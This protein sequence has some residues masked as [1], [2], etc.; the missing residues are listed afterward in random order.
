MPRSMAGVA[1]SLASRHRP[2]GVATGTSSASPVS[3]AIVRARP[4]ARGGPAFTSAEHGVWWMVLGLGVGRSALA[5]LSTG[6][7]ARAPPRG[8]RPCSTT[9]P[10]AQALDLGQQAGQGGGL[11]H[12]LAVPRVDLQRLDAEPLAGRLAY[13]SGPPGPVAGRAMQA[14]LTVDGNRYGEFGHSS[15]ARPGSVASGPLLLVRCVRVG[16]IRVGGILR[17]AITR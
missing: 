17:V 7:W 4:S 1:A 16:G 9:W 14:R 11:G 2:A 3:G 10:P 13:P 12:V 8:R 15:A 5:L 6:R